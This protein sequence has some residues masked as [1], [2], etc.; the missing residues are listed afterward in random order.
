MKTF[1]LLVVGLLSTAVAAEPHGHKRKHN[2]IMPGE[3]MRLLHFEHVLQTSSDS[4]L[5]TRLQSNYP[6]KA[7]M[8]KDQT[9]YAQSNI[10]AIQGNSSHPA[11][12]LQNCHVKGAHMQLVHQCMEKEHLPKKLAAWN[13]KT[14]GP[15]VQ[16]KH[17]W[18]DQQFSDEKSAIDAKIKDLGKNNTLTDLCKNLPKGDHKGGKDGKDGKD[19]KGEGKIGKDGKTPDGKT[20][21]P[22]GQKGSTGAASSLQ[23]AEAIRGGLFALALT[24]VMAVAIL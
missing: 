6:K 9:Q 16:K 21:G 19:G 10:T 20:T 17:S 22:P 14:T 12:W 1:S 8:I 3:C 23:S 11:D 4:K 13:D 24:L 5:M 15:K 7:A 18:S 2:G